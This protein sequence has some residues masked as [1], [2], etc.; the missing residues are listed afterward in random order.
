MPI[1]NNSYTVGSDI[2]GELRDIL[3]HNG[4]Q[5]HI[6]DDG[7][8]YSLAVQGHDSPLLTYPLTARQA[9]AL[10][11]WGTNSA[12]KKAYDTFVS[13][14]ANDFDVPKNFVSARNA[15][16]RVAMGLHGY[17]IGAGEYGRPN[18]L[19]WTPHQQDG[20]HLLESGGE[21]FPQGGPMVAERPDGRLKPGELQGGGY[22]FY[23]KGNASVQTAQQQASAQDVLRDLQMVITPIT[24]PR[25]Q[26]PA[27]PYNELVNSPVYFSNEKWQ[28]ALTSHGIIV[29]EESKTLTIQS[30]KTDVDMVY[31]LTDDEMETLTSNS[32]KE[33]SIEARIDTLNNIIKDD[34]ADK[35]TLDTLN[36]TERLQIALHPEVLEEFQEWEIEQARQFEGIGE[37]N[38]PM[39]ERSQYVQS[40]SRDEATV[41]GQALTH[42]NGEKG[43]YREGKYGREVDVGRITVAPIEGEGKYKMTAVINGEAITHEISQ[44]QYDKFMAV[45][46]YHR[47]VLFSKVFDEVDMKNRPEAHVGL[48]TKIFAALAAGAT[49]SAEMARG[50]FAAHGPTPELYGERFADRQAAHVYYKPGVDSP[51]DVASRAFEA[52]ANRTVGGMGLGR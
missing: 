42:L 47:M 48:G 8:G 33:H 28:T 45:D 30:E 5:A 31:D 25:S 46:D 21:V 50:R 43:W 35:I 12:D 29:D 41:F 23:Y 16:G 3:M 36:S 18:M 17:R 13:I 26:E 34:F 4:M 19:G 37:H 44:K 2:S 22:G 49:V 10:A 27:T 52:E 11:D 14:V 40:D 7:G 38:A 51:Q 6:V 9:Q 32:L 15:N 20:F 1:R 39:H 24:P